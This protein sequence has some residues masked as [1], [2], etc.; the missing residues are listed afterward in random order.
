MKNKV[1]SKSGISSVLA[2]AFLLLS[3]VLGSLM[4]TMAQNY[5]RYSETDA[6]KD[7][8]RMAAVSAAEI[9]KEQLYEGGI[10]KEILDEIKVLC[11]EYQNQDKVQSHRLIFRFS[12]ENEELTGDEADSWSIPDVEIQMKISLNSGDGKFDLEVFREDEMSE[13]LL[14]IP[15]QIEAEIC[16]GNTKEAVLVLKAQ[17]NTIYERD[18]ETG[19]RME[20]QWEEI[21]AESEKSSD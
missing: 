21:W 9:L 13:G 8:K 10:C 3:A 19:E 12:V 11:K 17:G 15:I 7:A 1:R 16:P 4:L 14:Y 5:G 20:L 18:G 2:L 6:S